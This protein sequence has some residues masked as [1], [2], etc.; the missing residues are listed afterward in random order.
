MISILQNIAKMSRLVIPSA[1]LLAQGHPKT[2]LDYIFSNKDRWGT[3]GL[4]I[5]VT[6][7][8]SVE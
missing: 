6:K 7:R 3:Q 1:L 8:I 5:T 2:P 4:T